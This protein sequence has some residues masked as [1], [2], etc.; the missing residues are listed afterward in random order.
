MSG[1]VSYLAG[2]AAEDVVE[3]SYR[4]RGCRL[5]AKRWRGGGGEIDLIFERSGVYIFVEVKQSRDFTSAADRISQAQIN[6]IY[7][8][9][10]AFLSNCP[11]GQDTN[12]RFDA[13]LV[14]QMGRVRVIENAFG[15]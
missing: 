5:C 15:F 3:N 2:I 6:R 10:S 7:N 9:A 8:A 4:A 1:E 14:D 13:A 11:G 12:T